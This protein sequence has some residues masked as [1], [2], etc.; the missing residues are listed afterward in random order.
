MHNGQSIIDAYGQSLDKLKIGDCVGVR[1]FLFIYLVVYIKKIKML[2]M[3]F[4]F[5][6]SSQ[7]QRKF[8][9]LCKSS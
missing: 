8:A 9:L 7:G 4:N 2:W 1:K 5:V 3:N 6:C